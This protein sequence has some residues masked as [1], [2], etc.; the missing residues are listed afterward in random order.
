MSAANESVALVSHPAG[1]MTETNLSGTI[2]SIAHFNSQ[3]S[4]PL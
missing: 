2:L 3:F 4:C 1:K